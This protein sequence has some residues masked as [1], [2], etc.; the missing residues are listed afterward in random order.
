[1]DKKPVH[2]M[3]KN[4]MLRSIKMDLSPIR[5]LLYQNVRW[6]RL[7]MINYESIIEWVTN[8][9]LYMNYKF[10]LTSLCQSNFISKA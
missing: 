10:R 6:I 2:W 1:M 3:H 9:S 7:D 5:Y 4:D 8:I